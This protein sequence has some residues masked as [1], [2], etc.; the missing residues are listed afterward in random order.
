MIFVLLGTQDSP[1]PRL[2]KEVEQ[3]LFEL[4]ITEKIYAQIGETPFKSEK[5]IT[6][7][8]FLGE[9]YKQL[10]Q[11]ARIIITHGGAGIL[12]NAIHLR[13]KIIAVP[14][15]ADFG[16]HN[17]NHQQ[18]LIQK[19]AS[20]EFIYESKNGIKEAILAIET[21]QPKFYT[22]KNTIIETITAFIEA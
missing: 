19:L 11:K 5:M 7:N 12:F 18:E 4:E 16:E 20:L 2:L 14:R 1:F 13:K 9:E 10:L 21:F 15:R 22:T 3:A 6:K 17:D 8:Y